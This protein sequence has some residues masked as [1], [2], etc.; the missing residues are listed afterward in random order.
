M[1]LDGALQVSRSKLEV[2]PL[3]QQKITRALRALEH[4]LL[5]RRRGCDPLLHACQFD[6]QDQLKV[7]P[8][9]G[10]KYDHL[11]DAVHEFGRKLPAR[12][13]SR[14]AV[15]LLVQLVVAFARSGSKA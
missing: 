6:V 11:V 15:D 14:R 4:K 1:T 2:R 9:Q 3:A 8:L 5:G 12:G 7:M 10:A 13:L